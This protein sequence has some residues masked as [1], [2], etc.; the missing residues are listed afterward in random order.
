AVEFT[1]PR[2]DLI[3]DLAVAVGSQPDLRAEADSHV[4]AEL[5]AKKI[6]RKAGT[7]NGEADAPDLPR[8]A[9]AGNDPAAV[10]PVVAGQQHRADANDHI[11][12]IEYVDIGDVFGFGQ[13][14]GDFLRGGW[15]GHG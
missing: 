2:D 1:Q 11:V 6:E 4:L 8:R 9:G 10:G 3:A 14:F 5:V 13:P 12:P 7:A 15:R